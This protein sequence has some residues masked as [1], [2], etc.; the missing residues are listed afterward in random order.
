MLALALATASSAAPRAAGSAGDE[1]G[2]GQ[3]QLE[4]GRYLAAAGNCVSCHTRPGGPS[5]AGGVSFS[6][7]IGVIYSS[8]ITPDADRG[9]GHWTAA[10][11]NR[12]MHEGVSR[13]GHRLFPA[14]PYPSF[15]RV[16]DA[17]VDAIFAYLRSIAPVRYQP[18]ANSLL[19]RLRWGMRVWNWLFFRPGRF[20]PDFKQSPEWNRGAYLVTG[21]GHCGACH[22]PRNLFLA[23]KASEAYT[24]GSFRAP[25]SA[26]RVRRWSA[27]NLT[28]SPA[29][30]AAWSL[31][32]LSHY[33][34]HGFAA[35][36]AGTFGPMNEVI[37][38]S[39]INLSDDDVRAMAVY[40]KSLPPRQASSLGAPEPQVQAGARIY[41]DACADCHGSAGE[42]DEDSAPPLRGSAVVQNPDA[43]SVI[44]LV[45]Y[46]PELL[47]EVPFGDWMRP[48]RDVLND[49]QTAAVI[50]FIRGS[51]GNLAPLV[52][53]TEIARQR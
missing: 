9:I 33:L 38:P 45:L 52:T 48:Y 50:N 51:W 17:D 28:P 43:A 35:T 25:V 46:G 11:L 29:G 19:F 39:L 4:R 24:G 30:L 13:D 44:N 5:F 34:K 14:F 8:N 36:R 22:T 16:S 49:A 6:T 37:L 31:D 53:P 21:L 27:V 26:G 18:P 41:A 32:E 42:G 40:L 47:K 2:S 7:P 3:Q 20:Q 10:D 12:A 1:T 23:E 15:T